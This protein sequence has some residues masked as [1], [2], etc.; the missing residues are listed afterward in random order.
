MVVFFFLASLYKRS[1]LLASFL[2][3]SIS[4]MSLL[5]GWESAFLH[6]RSVGQSKL[7]VAQGGVGSTVGCQKSAPPFIFKM[8]GKILGKNYYYLKAK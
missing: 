2:A 5:I 4:S 6:Q 8:Y 1:P 3:T 7:G